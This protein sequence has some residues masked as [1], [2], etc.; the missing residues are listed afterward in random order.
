MWSRFAIRQAGGRIHQASAVMTYLARLGIQQHNQPIPQ[1]HRQTQAILQTLVV[2]RRN[3]QL[4]YN[5]L[6]IMYLITV[7]LHVINNLAQLA[8]HTDIQKTLLMQ[9]LEQV[10]IMS[11]PGTH[12]RR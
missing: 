7:Q 10:L 6:Y 2:F 8:I 4:I 9:L 12:H 11:L 3:P 1:L 5:H